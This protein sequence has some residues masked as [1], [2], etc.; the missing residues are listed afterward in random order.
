MAKNKSPYLAVIM[1]LCLIIAGCN[2]QQKAKT[3]QTAKDYIQK[4]KQRLPFASKKTETNT[5]KSVTYSAEQLESPFRDQATTSASSGQKTLLDQEDIQQIK[6]VGVVMR[7]GK[8]WAIVA[9]QEKTLH[10]LA[11]GFIVGKQ[12][13]TVTKISN[14]SVEFETKTSEA[15]PYAS[16]FTLTLQE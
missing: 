1:I 9:G 10:A 2:D 3:K 14:N 16:I 7:K 13:A 12:H 5:I 8:K 4:I 15:N 6:L 11:V